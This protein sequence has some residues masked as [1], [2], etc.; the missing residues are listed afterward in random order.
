M[1]KKHNLSSILVGFGILKT[2][3]V[4]GDL[5]LTNT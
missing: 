5:H 2:I 3:K 1:I 4:N